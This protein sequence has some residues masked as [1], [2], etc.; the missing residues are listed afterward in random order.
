MGCATPFEFDAGNF[1]DPTAIDNPSLPLIPGTQL[2]LDGVADRGGGLLSHRVV[3]TVTD[4]TKVINGVETVVVWDVDASEGE[5]QEAELAFF[6][7]D[8]E[9]NVWNLGE[10][11]EVYE[12]GE[13]LGAPD[14]WI[15]GLRDA[16][17]GIHMLA[18]PR[19]GETYLQGYSPEIDFLDCASVKETIHE[20]CVP[21]G[22][23][24]D[25]LKI[26]ENSPLDEAPRGHQLKYHAAGIGVV[27]VSAV[28]DPEGETLVLT[29]VR[30]LGKKSLANARRNA[31]Q[32]DRRAYEVSDVYRETLP[33]E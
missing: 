4:L 1:S 24:A 12:G 10:Y 23:Y 9:G 6:A 11:P 21:A 13:F 30:H 17:A 8:D 5:V 2:V 33:A 3:F 26:Q 28:G 20:V 7:Q 27:Q 15:A 22:C 32:L 14:T 19:S 25:V 18:E 16:Q 31:L 29:Q